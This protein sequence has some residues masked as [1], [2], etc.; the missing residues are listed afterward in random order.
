MIK[1]ALL[2]VVLTSF[3]AGCGYTTNT[4]LPPELDS[5]HVSNFVNKINPA[6]EVSDKRMSYTYWPGLEN[7]I[8]RAVIDGFIFDRHLEVKTEA[9]ASMVLKGELVD[10]KQFPLSYDRSDNVEEMRTQITV[11]LELYD[12]T[13]KEL[14]WSE[15]GFTG[16]SSYNLAG[17]N[18]T[19]EAEGVR[20]AVQDIALRVVERV[21]EAW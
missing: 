16:W 10:Y 5:I 11:N 1:K 19:T 2:A 3:L 17:P 12:N 14:I 15:K 13:T 4:L 8:T 20:G 21:V 18:A 6:A 9:K 7:Q